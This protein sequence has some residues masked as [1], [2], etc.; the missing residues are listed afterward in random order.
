MRSEMNCGTDKS[1]PY[2]LF[3][4]RD[5]GIAPYICKFFILCLKLTFPRV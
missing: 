5:V 3:L 4:G 1:V 2:E